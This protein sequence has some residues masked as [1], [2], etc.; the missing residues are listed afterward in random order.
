[1]IE[2]A[3]LEEELAYLGDISIHSDLN[4]E[5][6]F[7]EVAVRTILYDIVC[8]T[9]TLPGWSYHSDVVNQYLAFMMADVFLKTR[10]A[11]DILDDESILSDRQQVMI[12]E[13][14]RVFHFA[15]E[16][17]KEAREAITRDNMSEGTVQFGEIPD[18]IFHDCP[19]FPD[20]DLM[21]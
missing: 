7:T 16:K 10:E 2:D 6:T 9:P 8:D 17:M 12:S 4:L 15:Q 19:P 5:C 11:L 14:R 20:W 1:M 18:D 3:S 21:L 13:G